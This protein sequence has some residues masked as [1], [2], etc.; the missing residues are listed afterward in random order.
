[1][2]IT[3]SLKDSHLVSKNCK[4]S[5]NYVSSCCHFPLQM[6]KLCAKLEHFEELEMLLEK[7]RLELER[8]RQ[9]VYADRIRYAEGQTATRA[10]ILRHPAPS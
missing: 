3:F 1:M 4:L 10:S 2:S 6:K 8:A 9:Q 5:T 7:E